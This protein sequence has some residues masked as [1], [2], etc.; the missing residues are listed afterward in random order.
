MARRQGHWR[1]A[2]TFTAVIIPPGSD[3]IHERAE[4]L[5]ITPERVLQEYARIAFADIRNIVTWTN[6]GMEINLTGDDAAAVLEIVTSASTQKPYR[7]KLHDKTPVLGALARCLGMLP[8]RQPAPND[9]DVTDDD[10]EDPRET[11]IREIDRLV[12]QDAAES[13]DPE[14]EPGQSA[15]T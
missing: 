10:G 9:G 3:D 14:P 12:A 6:E 2:A 13:G 11:L 4:R 15:Q 8:A 5:G 1:D 7:V